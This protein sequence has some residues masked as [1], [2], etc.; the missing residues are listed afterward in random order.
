L[1][2]LVRTK[3]IISLF[4]I[5]FGPFAL[6]FKAKNMIQVKVVLILPAEQL[7]KSKKK[8]SK[9]VS[10]LISETFSRDEINRH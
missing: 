3:A 9:P 2:T 7:K 10:I 6:D 5:F 1:L 8:S 4:L